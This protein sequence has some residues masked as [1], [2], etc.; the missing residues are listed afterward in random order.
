M[1][2]VFRAWSV[3]LWL[4]PALTNIINIKI[5]GVK[6]GMIQTAGHVGV[7]SALSRTKKRAA[8]HPTSSARSPSPFELPAGSP[9]ESRP[10]RR[11]VVEGTR[12]VYRRDSSILS[13][14]QKNSPLEVLP[15]S[16]SCPT[17][18]LE[19]H[20]NSSFASNLTWDRVRSL[21]SRFQRFCPRDFASRALTRPLVHCS[22]SSGFR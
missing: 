1:R 18:V 3:A 21:E 14:D 2:T 19:V 16:S 22:L 5:L 11:I 9:Y 17:R 4:R 10:R 13:S 20:A 6:I 12:G 7:A 8:L 15:C